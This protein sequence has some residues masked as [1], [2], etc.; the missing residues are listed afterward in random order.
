MGADAISSFITS[1]AA[2]GIG[3]VITV[4]VSLTAIYKFFVEFVEANEQA[5]R[6]H[7]NKPVYRHRAIGP[8]RRIVYLLTVLWLA[9]CTVAAVTQ[10][11]DTYKLLGAYGLGVV[12]LVITTKTWPRTDEIHLVDPGFKL[13]VPGWISYKRGVIALDSR[14]IT[15]TGV[16]DGSQQLVDIEVAYRWSRTKDDGAALWQSVIG[17]DNLETTIDAALSV[18]TQ[19]MVAQTNRV[20]GL[21][22]RKM[23]T[24]G[25]RILRGSRD[26]F[27]QEFGVT[28]HA[29]GIA[30]VGTPPL[31]KVAEAISYQ[32]VN[33]AAISAVLRD[34][35]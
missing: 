6:A 27:A 1:G 15:L 31:V 14:T 28:L 20:A 17:V 10:P 7:N 8:I 3:A 33:P 34:E 2:K 35:D 4:L 24:L 11:I 29:V 16:T 23:E 18:A 19:Q 22:A 25:N 30:K 32:G 26:F 13:K 21:N 9:V 12:A 5:V